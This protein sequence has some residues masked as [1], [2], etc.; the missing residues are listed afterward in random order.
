MFLNHWLSGQGQKHLSF[1][2]LFLNNSPVLLNRSQINT[3]VYLQPQIR[4]YSP[5][6]PM[7]KVIQGHSITAVH[8]LLVNL[9]HLIR[10]MHALRHHWLH[11][12]LPP[13]H[14]AWPYT[15]THKQGFLKPENA[16]RCF[17]LAKC[18]QQEDQPAEIAPFPTQP[19]ALQGN[20]LQVK[21]GFLR[22]AYHHSSQWNG[23]PRAK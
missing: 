14:C 23:K 5:E 1:S 3:I 9:E 10:N 16:Y 13:R 19:L 15:H 12:T 11:C 8:M 7:S 21:R 20:F 4:G 2:R 22:S 18:M 17:K 6:N